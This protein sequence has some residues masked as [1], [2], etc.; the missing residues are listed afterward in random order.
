[1]RGSYS[2]DD[3]LEEMEKTL[4]QQL[5]TAPLTSM[6]PMMGGTITAGINHALKLDNE[7]AGSKYQSPTSA[8][9]SVVMNLGAKNPIDGQWN[10]KDIAWF[11][12]MAT[13][14]TGVPMFEWGKNIAKGSYLISQDKGGDD[15]I[16]NTNTLLTGK[17]H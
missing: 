8:G 12:D 5:Y 11:F 13:Y 14:I 16:D 15:L 4:A 6:F 3:G 2:G 9:I 10:E 1:M 17:A 7:F